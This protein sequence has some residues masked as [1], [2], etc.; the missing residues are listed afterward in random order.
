M[1]RAD[2]HLALY[3]DQIIALRRAHA[4]GHGADYAEPFAAFAAGM[5]F[6]A[7]IPQAAATLAELYRLAYPGHSLPTL[8]EDEG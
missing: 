5:L 4:A 7:G 6:G 8:W 1:A 3:R 2:D